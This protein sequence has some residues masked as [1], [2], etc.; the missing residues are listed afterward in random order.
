LDGFFLRLRILPAVYDHITFVSDV[1]DFDAAEMKFAELHGR[2]SNILLAIGQ[3]GRARAPT[4]N[5]KTKEFWQNL[6]H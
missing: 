6:N 3:M 4:Q 1:I 5:L 2:V